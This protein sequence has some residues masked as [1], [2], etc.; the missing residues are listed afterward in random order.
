MFVSAHQLLL[1]ARA[2]ISEIPLGQ[3]DGL[4]ADPS[5]LWL[6]VGEPA[7]YQQG[8]IAAALNIPRG[9]LEF[10]ISSDPQLQ[11]TQRRIVVYCKT[12]GR[13][14][15]AAQTLQQMG[16]VAVYA[17]AGGYD[18]WQASGRPLSSPQLSFE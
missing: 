2:I 3:A 14:A 12:G 13:A 10:V 1:K 7:E 15:L 18:A 11:H 9:M 6:D 17:L 5:V 4:L 16:F 8:H